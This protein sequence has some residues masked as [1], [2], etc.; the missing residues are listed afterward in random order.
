[1]T[2]ASAFPRFGRDRRGTVAIEMAI[3]FP[4]IL[5]VMLGFYEL[6]CYIRAVAIVERT[7]ASVANIMSRQTSQLLD[8]DSSTN[9]LNLGTYVDAVVRQGKPLTI[10][11]SGEVFLSAVGM[12]G[13]TPTVL[14]QR[15]SKFTVSGGASRLGV[16]NAAA[17]LPQDLAAAMQ[18]NININA[19]VVEIVYRFEPFAMTKYFWQG[20]A[21]TVTFSRAAY[22]RAR[23][24]N[25]NALG[26]AAANGCTALP[27]PPA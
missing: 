21:G 23:Q 1:M 7:A 26:S 15:R 27:T 25:Q 3:L 13:G 16:Q 24:F 19:L 22:F 6:Y 2:A 4:I 17:T 10:D 14:W 8:C 12:V 20:G 5:V 11:T 9:A 18:A